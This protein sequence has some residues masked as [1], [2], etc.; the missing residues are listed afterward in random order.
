[1]S[2]SGHL[3]DGRTQS[4]LWTSK[5]RSCLKLPSIHPD[6]GISQRRIHARRTKLFCR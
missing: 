1:M 5:I 4:K 6:L 3:A 2:G